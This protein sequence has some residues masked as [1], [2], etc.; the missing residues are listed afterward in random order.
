MKLALQ[1]SCYNGARY[2]PYL[3]ASLKEQTYQD[4]HLYVLD[5]ASDEEN[6]QAIE[7]AVADSGLPVSL[8][9]VS[10]NIGFAG[11]HNFLFEKHKNQSQFVQL[12]NDDAI[13]E[14]DFLEKLVGYLDLE[15]HQLCAAVTGQIRRW[16]FE[17]RNDVTRGKT[18][19]IDSLG[20][21]MNWTGGMSDRGA[22]A[23]VGSLSIPSS[24]YTILGPS[25]CL[26]MYRVAA[27]R[28]VT[29]DDHL[30][31]PTYRIYK[32]D[33]DLALRL[34][35]I[36]YTAMGIPAALA[37][38]RRGFGVAQ[39]SKASFLRPLNENTALSYRNHLWMLYAHVSLLSLISNRIGILPYEIAKLIY[40]LFRSPNVVASAVRDTKKN[41]SYL[42]TKRTFVFHL[43]RHGRY[44][45]D[46]NRPR[47]PQ[48]EFAIIIVG[49]NDLSEECFTSVA[50]ARSA[51][52]FSTTLIVVDNGSKKFH[53]NEFVEQYSPDAWVLL[54]NDD[55][56]YGRSMN[57]GVAQIDAE[58]YFILNPDTILPDPDVFTKMRTYLKAHPEV[59]MIGPRINN[60]SGELQETCRRF[61]SWYQP[62]IQRSSLK[63]TSFGKKY[64]QHFLMKDVDHSVAQP[65]DWIQG[66]AMCLPKK[67]WNTVGGFDDRYWLYFEDVDLCRK[68]WMLGKRVMY[69]PDIVIQHA[70]G[71][72]SALIKSFV[73]NII[74][75]KETRG[76]IISWI[77]YMRKWSGVP[78]P[79]SSS[80]Q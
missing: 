7:K 39:F 47:P 31:D 5:N 26:P 15:S 23:L 60:F 6:K 76:H 21:Q 13:L 72:Q 25:G 11:A 8:F 74:K 65:V 68:V 49:H 79:S 14:P 9:R 53:A 38:H 30:F 42:S 36:G 46:L 78:L 48:V 29:P 41:W 10:P 52:P 69:V 66:S 17:A 73:M 28:R 56:G 27:V 59:G 64:L 35:A 32:E 58:Y 70:H 3:F 4:W 33:C 19:I 54:R 80:K 51:T 2:L 77:K 34:K 12:L 43:K 75:T 63:N 20:I 57:R 37:Y 44:L 45:R 62:L 1:L 16:N 50:T 24:P 71:R 61:P 55:H 40:W 18:D 22:G 67:V